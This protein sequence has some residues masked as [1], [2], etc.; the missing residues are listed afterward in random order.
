MKRLPS[1]LLKA[2]MFTG[3]WLLPF[4]A[5]AQGLSGTYTINPGSSKARNYKSFQ[6][7]INDLNNYGV[8]GP[9]VFRCAAATHRGP[10]DVKPVSGASA[11][12]TVTFYSPH[13]DSV[14]IS[15]PGASSSDYTIHLD[16]ADHF[17]FENIKIS[18][19]NI[20]GTAV[21]LNNSADHNIIKGCEI[22]VLNGTRYSTSGACIALSQY[23]RYPTSGYGI[24]GS[25]NTFIDNVLRGGSQSVVINGIDS[26][27]GRGNKL[28]NC[29]IAESRSGLRSYY[30]DSLEMVG[31]KV[32]D[33]SNFGFG[34]LIGFSS[35]I[36]IESNQITLDNAY[37]YLYAINLKG[38]NGIEASRVVNNTLISD[39]NSYNCYF[40]RVDYMSI[41]HNSFSHNGNYAMYL[42]G[43]T[44]DLRNNNFYQS[45]NGYCLRTDSNSNFVAWDYNNYKAAT[46]QLVDV[47]GRRFLS[48]PA[49]A[50]WN[51]NYNQHN[52]SESPGFKNSATDLHLSSTATPLLAPHMGIDFDV[53][54]NKRCNLKT[55]IGADERAISPFG[56]K[57]SF[58]VS[59]TLIVGSSYRIYNNSSE[60]VNRC[61]W[62]VN[63]KFLSDSFHFDYRPASTGIDIIQ[64]I[65]ETCSGIDTASAKV[66][67]VI[68]TLAP[69]ADFYITPAS[70]RVGQ[71]VKLVDLSTGGPNQWKW[72]IEPKT[73]YNYIT[74]KWEP[75]YS[76]H[77]G[78]DDTSANPLVQFKHPGDYDI[79]LVARNSLGK[80][81][82]K[83]SSAITISDYVLM[84]EKGKSNALGG[85][86]YDDGGP[87]GYYSYSNTST[88]KV[89][90]TVISTCIGQIE[91]DINAFD[92]ANGDYLRVYD[93]YN[94]SG[95]PLWNTG[96][97][98]RGM[99]GDYTDA[100]VN[101]FFTAKTGSAYIEFETDNSSLTI[102]PGFE[103]EWKVKP[104]SRSAPKADF[105]VADTACLGYRL[106]LENASTGNYTYAEWDIDADGIV[107]QKGDTFSHQ[108]KSSGTKKIALYLHSE[109]APTDTLIKQII[110]EKVSR[111]PNP[112]IT[113]S[114]RTAEIGD[115][116]TL[117]SKYTY[118]S[119]RTE[120]IISPSNY[121]IISGNLNSDVLSVVFTK[122]GKY[123][124]TVK[125]SNEIGTGSKTLTDHIK[126]IQY[127]SPWVIGLDSDI[128]ISRVIVGDIDN[129]SSI[130]NSEFEYYPN[131][132]T[133]F[134]IGQHYP[135]TIEGKGTK[136]MSRKVWVDW[137]IDGDFDDAGELVAYEPQATTKSFT[138]T[139]K[140][141]VTL[142]ESGYTRLRVSVNYKNFTNGS[143]GPHQSGEFEDYRI[144]LSNTDNSP[145]GLELFGGKDTT[146]NVYSNWVEPGYKA[147]DRIDGNLTS[148]VK[149]SGTVNT[150]RL[151]VYVLTYEV[152]DA[153]NNLSIAKRTVHVVDNEAPT[154][155]LY[156]P[157]TLRAQL[158]AR[159][160]DPLAQINDNYD[161]NLQLIVKGKLD[162]TKIG[163]YKR[164]YCVTDS[165]GNGPVC[166][167]R[168]I[169][170]VDTLPPVITLLGANPVEVD[171]FGTYSEPG[172]T[173]VDDD[174]YRV[175]ISGTWKGNT[176][177]LSKY[178]K[179]YTA[180]DSSGNSSS[181]IRTIEVVDR[182]APEL[183]LQGKAID[184]VRL[185]ATYND[186]GVT[187]TDNYYSGLDI[188]ITKS[189][190][191]VDTQ[192]EGTYT[193]QYQGEDPSGNLSNMVSRVVIVWKD[194]S[195][196]E[197]P[198]GTHVD[199][200][201]NPTSGILNLRMENSNHETILVEV[202]N[203]L[204]QV[205]LSDR[206]IVNTQTGELNV[207]GLA[208]GVYQLRLMNQDHQITVPFRKVN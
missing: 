203:T 143:C 174:D 55:A 153:K 195:V 125:K 34:F 169:E 105:N 200:F 32:H 201:P 126:I 85:T 23:A 197:N 188:V 202:V 35:N 170:V 175:V 68:P 15:L 71:V 104:T 17:I 163:F 38:F 83:V 160:I 145:P 33:L 56:P 162:T 62:L 14:R 159:F 95:K 22:E 102:G 39:Y 21:F 24:F 130:G 161:K 86:L 107:E 184:S 75:T 47:N 122:K 52:W 152:K 140:V 128:G 60:K 146:L 44:I 171:V 133:R 101:H 156:G 155:S 182:I 12:N 5:L 149:V 78:S 208:P 72:T 42:I 93:G 117:T 96:Y 61:S 54:S 177:A 178:T 206:M 70:A 45:G 150:N 67:V 183:S 20:T 26:S 110:V 87:K 88:A 157:D 142:P 58:L 48:I 120:W 91:F 139:I 99:T 64:L 151:G 199:V 114:R 111:V 148:E 186:P 134:E 168:I 154:I 18:K 16:G 8:T 9:V 4:L 198:E 37:N 40:Y 129:S 25:Y 118:C 27:R 180:I 106:E 147:L 131:P 205:V 141:P 204:G 13:I 187:A 173:V 124:L 132:D 69:D 76:W 79:Q 92:L 19:P 98:A 41:A 31:C 7:A 164:R 207:S 135:I 167:Q 109:C 138:D 196:G 50:V 89:C 166:V 11:T 80:D 74:N 103:I 3:L 10:F 113:S 90:T 116:I 53:D 119:N 30:Q 2:L 100:S 82:I 158:G 81:S 51:R 179:T 185:Y 73:F 191:F 108:F 6:G 29:D 181:A 112:A 189:G 193:I 192:N 77:S 66:E 144:L 136:P 94:S 97:S 43:N 137:N 190:T 65:F 172:Y 63:G 28:I 59:D 194:I 1:S 46:S 123:S 36:N 176:S 57:A 127:C 121:I 49:L 84:C 115:T 165:S